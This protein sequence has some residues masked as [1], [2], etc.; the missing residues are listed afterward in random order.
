MKDRIVIWGQ[1]EKDVDILIAIRLL[2]NSDIIKIWTFPK[3]ET[4]IN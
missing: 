2:Q 1:D 3:K 4:S